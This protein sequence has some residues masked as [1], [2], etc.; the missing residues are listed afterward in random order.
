MART[1]INER[2]EI[3]RLIR[4][5]GRWWH[6]IEV[7]PGIVTPGD[8]SNRM[9]LPIL[10]DIG[11]PRRM[12]GLRVLDIG[13][14][15]G[16]F[17][18]E[19]EAR[20]ASVVAIDFVPEDYTGFAVASKILGSSVEYRMENVYNLNPESFGL[21]DVVLFM[22]V[23]YHLRNPL[24][25]LDA[26]RSVMKQGGQLFVGTM[27]IDEYFQLPDRT[28]TSLAALNPALAEVPL[29]QAYPRDTL[30]GDFTNCFA[31]N[32]AALVAA[33]TEAQFKP[34]QVATVSMGGYARAEAI[35]DPLTAKYQRLDTRLQKT[36]F[37]P[38]IPYFLDEE[39][40]IH[41]VTGRAR[42]AEAPKSSEPERR[43]WQ[44]WRDAT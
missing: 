28:I 9:K 13:C 25:G 20:G 11:L 39:G 19:M 36:P 40:S 31:P 34:Q 10:D 4:A 17:S 7:A 37:D 22:G 32:R 12:D 18:F 33:L 38:S 14:S 27:M 26:I 8:D 6:Q 42:D 29:W 30:N 35:T 21:F 41:E 24:G 23:L 1:R 3:E 5:H 16:F 44:F 15:D 2:A 43:W